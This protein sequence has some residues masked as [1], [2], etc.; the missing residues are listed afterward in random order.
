MKRPTFFRFAKKRYK[1]ACLFCDYFLLLRERC[2]AMIISLKL[3]NFYSLRDEVVIDF[4]S[5]P[6]RSDRV[7]KDSNLI[8]FKNDKFVNVI[9][10]FGSNAAGKS[11]LI[12]AVSFCRNFILNSHLYH[13]GDKLD[14]QPFKFDCDEPSTFEISF[15]ADGVEYEYSFA[16]YNGHVISEALYQFPHNRKSKVFTREETNKYSY[17]KSVLSRPREIESN[18]GPQTLFLSRASSMNRPLAQTIYSFFRDSVLVG[19]PVSEISQL[20]PIVF[21]VNKPML[22]KGF[23]VSDS[24]I[25]DIR[26]VRDEGG[27]SRLTSYHR[28]DPSIAFDFE[29]E[30]SDGTKRLL[31]VL[32]AI[33]GGKTLNTTIFMDEF[34]LKLHLRL[35]E[36]VLDVIRSTGKSQLVFTSHNSNLINPDKMRREQIVFVNKQADGNSEFIPLCEF[37]D[38]SDRT[39]IQKAYLQGRFDAVPYIGD[40][41]DLFSNNSRS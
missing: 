9:G 24:D 3:K 27:R 19:L 11:N 21:E 23:E 31:Y 29:R 4:T 18:T 8:E 25:I 7:E 37:S 2:I 5:V 22:L 20:D 41:R 30:E 28:E 33:L 13:E 26:L 16:L 38:V 34:D 1:N 36:F 35:A 10:L 32:M 6:L 15:V 14:Y 40:T 39:D 17:G 12:K